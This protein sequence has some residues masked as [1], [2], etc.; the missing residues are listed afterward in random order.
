MIKNGYARIVLLIG[1][2]APGLL[3]AQSKTV[4]S[5]E[6]VFYQQEQDA[7]RLEA[8][9]AL[10]DEWSFL[11]TDTAWRW[12]ERS[13]AL[14]QQL[15]NPALLARSLYQLGAAAYDKRE[16]QQAMAYFLEALQHF[17]ALG[18]DRRRMDTRLEIGLIYQDMGEYGQAREYLDAFYQFYARQGEKEAPNIIFALNQFVVLFEQ[19]QEVDSMLHYAKATLAA[20]ERYGQDKYLANI[21]NNLASVYLY[22][23]NYPKAQYHF[24][25]A[26]RIGF[27]PNKVGRYYN[28][29]ALA[30]MNRALGALDSSAYYAQQALA[31]AQSFGD[32]EKESNIHLFLSGLY[33]DGGDFEQAFHQ[34]DTFT[35]L[36]DSLTALRHQR[37]LSELS[38]RYQT[39]EKEARI[40]Q[41]QLELQREA[42]RRN[43]IIFGSLLGFLLLGGI[44]LFWRKR[45]QEQARQTAMELKYQQAEA[46]RLRELSDLK[47]NFFA[48]ISH[49]F[50]TPLT[51]LLGPLREMER[52][53]DL[54]AITKDLPK[55]RRQG[56]RLLNLADQMLDLSR[57]ESG[58]MP[59]RLERHDLTQKVAVVAA[60]FESLA[61]QKDIRLNTRLPGQPLAVLL[62]TDKLEKVLNNLIGNAIKFTPGGG[63]VQVE[64]RANLDADTVQAQI[65]VQDDGPGIPEEQLPHIFERFYQGQPSAPTA[66]AG[67]G[68]GLALTKELVSFMGG[69]IKAESPP[70]QG[71]RFTLSIP[72]QQAKP[73][74]PLPETPPE[75]PTDASIVLLAEDNTELRQYIRQQLYPAYRVLETADGQA[76][77]RLAQERLPDLIISDVRMPGMDGLDFCRTVKEDERTSH[78]P[79]ILL[80]ALADQ[81]DV[82]AGLLTGADAYLTKPFDAEALRIRV[83]QMIQQRQQLREKYARALKEVPTP[84]AAEHPADAAFLKKVEQQVLQH[85][86]QEDFSIEAL[87]RAVG[88]SRSQLHRKIK[89]LTDQSPSVFVRT[90]RLREAYRLLRAQKGNVS[91]VAHQV[92]MP[93]LAHFSRSFK[94]WF[95][96]PPSQI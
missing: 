2:L 50:R 10:C 91:E 16:L 22:A 14:A 3:I 39:Q 80:T 30:D 47:S 49:E 32:L 27:G 70:S 37:D 93:N 15:D 68:I 6:A 11:Q 78:I 51:L 63:Q 12:A 42:N 90:L 31:V 81:A 26:E 33:Q 57:L 44:F 18:D 77:L 92:G 17:E 8:A 88:M 74:P 19:M 4:D 83:A 25:Q 23:K 73:E 21:H 36:K 43:R 65:Q 35:Q 55:L 9:L 1:A 79:I 38:I 66:R 13:Y 56:E 96:K 67:A 94:E 41:Q 72:F 64:L 75:T 34:L 48:N 29:Y 46:E 24:Q 45:Q 69:E 60:A 76:G 40:A 5:L 7:L 59:E 87:G 85:L 53:Q 89:A 20:A 62:D 54:S 52:T 84:V 28:F 58:A 95:G 82:R 71:A 86:D 61:E